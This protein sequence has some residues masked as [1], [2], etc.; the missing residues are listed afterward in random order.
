MTVKNSSMRTRSSLRSASP[1]YGL[2]E[3]L[4]REIWEMNLPAAEER[5]LLQEAVKK[6]GV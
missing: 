6:A 3:Q 4:K 2:Y 1:N 5:V